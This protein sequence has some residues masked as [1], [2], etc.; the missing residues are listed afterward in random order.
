MR[1]TVVLSALTLSACATQ[2]PALSQSA[3]TH[4]YA[5]MPTS[6]AQRVWECAGI[7]N[8]IEG[9]KFVLKLQ[10]RPEN[11]GGE[12]WATRE[13]GKRLHCSQAEMDAP[14]MGNFSSP[15]KSPRP[16]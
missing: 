7:S 10:G 3:K 13:R 8:V 12:I 15:P 9:Q 16:R 11:W 6:E 1:F 5:P 4:L 2:P 14:D